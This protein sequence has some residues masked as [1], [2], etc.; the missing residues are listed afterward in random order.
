M[1]VYEKY[2]N[3]DTKMLEDA[4]TSIDNYSLK[5]FYNRVLEVYRRAIKEYW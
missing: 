2:Q 5:T 3:K 4:I 1:L